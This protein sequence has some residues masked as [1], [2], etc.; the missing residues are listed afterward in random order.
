MHKKKKKF[1]QIFLENCVGK[2]L[3]EDVCIAGWTLLTELFTEV[4]IDSR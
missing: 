3:V 1:I 4:H 2:Y